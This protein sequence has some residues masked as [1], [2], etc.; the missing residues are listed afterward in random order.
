MVSVSSVGQM[1][2]GIELNIEKMGAMAMTVNDINVE[3]ATT[4]IHFQRVQYYMIYLSYETGMP[5]QARFF[6]RRPKD[7]FHAN[8]SISGAWP[9]VQYVRLFFEHAGVSTLRQ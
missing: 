1:W 3:G 2:G 4:G 6:S 8:F 9:K 5:T 7:A